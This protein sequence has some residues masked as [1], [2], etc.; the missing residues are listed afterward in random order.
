MTIQLV[1]R[2]ETFAE[3]LRELAGERTVAVDTEAASFHRYHPRIYLIQ[4]ST[5]TNTVVI[6]PIAVGDLTPIGDLLANDEVV[7]I[8]HDADYDLRLFDREFGFHARNLFDTRIAAQFLNEPGISL[9]ALLEKYFGVRPDKRFQRADWSMRPLSPAMLDY[10]AGDTTHLYQLSELLRQN[11]AEIGRLDWVT[12][13]CERAERTRWTGGEP[14]PATDFTRIKGARAL[15]HRG[16]ARLRELAA[17]RARLAAELDRAE[18]RIISNETLLHLAQHPVSEVAELRGVRGVGRDLVER[19]G[20]DIVGALRR[21]EEVP[22]DQLPRFPRGVRQ[23]PDPAYD[24]RVAA[25]KE[26]RNQLAETFRLV[27]GVLC[28]NGTLEAIARY[29]PEHASDLAAISEVRRWQIGAIGETL[30]QAMHHA[31]QNKEHQ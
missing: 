30:V 17:W 13:E 6:D 7:K 5:P 1:E 4:I 28:P 20:Q 26:A 18:F 24:A 23:A 12:E 11:L 31:Y 10:A 14:D 3:F 27:P 2:R 29:Q 19:H 8:F 22:V 25:L 9:G 21:A 16:L 15:D